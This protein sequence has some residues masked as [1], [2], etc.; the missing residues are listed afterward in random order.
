VAGQGSRRGT[1]LTVAGHG[2]RQWC[3]SVVRSRWRL[4]PGLRRANDSVTGCGHLRSHRA[5]SAAGR[6][7]DMGWWLGLRVR[8]RPSNWQHLS[9]L[10]G[11]HSDRMARAAGSKTSARIQRGRPPPAVPTR[12]QP[13]RPP[14]ASTVVGPR[15]LRHIHRSER[16]CTRR[17][18]SGLP[19]TESP[20][21]VA[22]SA[23]QPSCK[24]PTVLCLTWPDAEPSTEFG[25]YPAGH[26]SGRG[27]RARLPR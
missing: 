1:P 17:P 20:A 25:T 3:G 8:R 7:E 16:V 14:S 4:C 24:R 26:P 6:E 19:C 18:P 9:Q 12:C 15:V 13:D 5:R 27:V 11:I 10:A 22:Q 23:E 21:G 2:T